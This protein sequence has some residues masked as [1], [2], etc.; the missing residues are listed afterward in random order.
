MRLRGFTNQTIKL[1]KKPSKPQNL[2]TP[3]PQNLKK[4][5]FIV[6]FPTKPCNIKTFSLTL[7]PLNN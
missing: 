1:K 4:R 3:K 7:L 5:K 6:I 2:I